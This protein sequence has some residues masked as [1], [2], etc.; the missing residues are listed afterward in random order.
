MVFQANRI[1]T[2]AWKINE[3]NIGF[4]ID[5]RSQDYVSKA[6]DNL[7]VDKVNSQTIEYLKNNKKIENSSNLLKVVDIF[8]EIGSDFCQGTAKSRHIRIYLQNSLA[9][10]CNS[11]QI[12]DTYASKKNGLAILC[13]EYYPD[14]LFAYTLKR[15]NLT[16]CEFVDSD[17]FTETKNRERFEFK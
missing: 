7:Y 4:E 3:A 6:Y 14:S 12:N 1:A 2:E 9:T 5:Q 13:Y 10:I 8:E 15:D 17:K 11:T 16:T